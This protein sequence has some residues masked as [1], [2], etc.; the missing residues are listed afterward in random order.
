[1]GAG[2]GYVRTLPMELTSLAPFRLALFTTCLLLS[3]CA[4]KTAS[5]QWQPRT[6]A[7]LAADIAACEADARGVDMQSPNAYSDSRY[8]AAAALAGAMARTDVR[9]GGAER[10]YQAIR[11]ICMTRKGWKPAV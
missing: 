3:A 6:D 7:D 8:G 2:C 4:T 10:A 1:M 5:L 9:S 11:D